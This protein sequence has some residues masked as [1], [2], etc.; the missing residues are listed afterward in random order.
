MWQSRHVTRLLTLVALAA[1]AALL[2]DYLVPN[3]RF[4]GFHADCEQVL[5]SPFG[6]ALGVP[7]PLVG[8][9]TFAALFGLSLFPASGAGRLL[10]PLALGAGAGGL[11]L[12]LLQVLVLRHV[13]PYCMAVDVSALAVALLEA[14]GVRPEGPP[15]LGR[16][17]R[18][19]WLAA[20]VAALAAG[21]AL[22]SAGRWEAPEG[23][24]A[25]PQIRALWRPD[26]VTVV[27]V[28]DF[29]CPHCRRM[30]A[31]VMQLLREEGD[32]IHFVRLTAPMPA[33]PHARDASRAFLCADGQ[34]RGDD[35]A[36]LL[37]AADS[38]TPQAC[39]EIASSLGLAMDKYRACVTDRATEERL[40]ADAAWVRAASPRGL[41]VV[42]VQDRMFFGVQPF[43][44]L[45]GAVAEARPPADPPR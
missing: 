18:S 6:R 31:V 4:C 9:L 26:K 28:A 42:W 13:C 30:H 21:G 33:H 24:G 23:T 20:A 3:P 10:R 1:S 7:L 34:G 14:P 11:V 40:D 38:L 22:G 17:A 36:Q 25:P 44:A 5:S 43:A 16:R 29:E 37:F 41:P 8:V 27:E 32:R 45:R 2:V 39:E 15:A 35:M 12:I 19:F